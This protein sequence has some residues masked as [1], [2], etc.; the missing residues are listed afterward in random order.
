MTR[1]LSD[2]ELERYARHVIMEEIGEEGQ[3]KLLSSS[4]L[5]VGAGGLGSPALLYLAAA[6]VGRIGVIDA[7]AVDVTNLQRQI[8]HSSEEIGIAKVTSARDRLE[9]L[10][11]DIVIEAH[12]LR[13][14][15]DN[16]DDVLAPYDLILDGSDNFT[17]R[18][19]INDACVRLKKTLISA[20]IV[21]FEGQ[22]STFKP[23]ADPGVLPCYRCIFPAQPDPNLVP[24]CDTVGVLGPVAGVMGTMQA[25]EG[26]KELLGLG[27]SLAG[28][29]MLYS[30]LD[31]TTR[32]IRIKADPD[33]P[34]CS[35]KG[36]APGREGPAQ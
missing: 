34:C 30:A 2:G 23:W 5:V 28:R 15:P 4:V 19:L 27:T 14:G 17:T 1:E 29:L 21:R 3:A 33:C 16:A 13:L 18:Y 12:R 24:R 31:A 26:L 25:V 11:P 22:I 36:F 35:G 8:L 9:A 6:G 10:N 20:A 7:D 32:T